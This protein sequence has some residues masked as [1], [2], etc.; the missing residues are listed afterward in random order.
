MRRPWGLWGLA[1]VVVAGL[2]W[3]TWDARG[4]SSAG[5]LWVERAEMQEVIIQRAATGFEVHFIVIKDKWA[6]SDPPGY[7]VD[8]LLVDDIVKALQDLRLGEPFLPTE[9]LEAYGLGLD[10]WRIVVRAGFK[11]V[12]FRLGEGGPTASTYL[13]VEGEDLVFPSGQWLVNRLDRPVEAFVDMRLSH[14]TPDKITFVR[15]Q[16]SVPIPGVTDPERPESELILEIRRQ[17]D[18]EWRDLLTD[19]PLST[20]RVEA[21]LGGILSLEG[22]SLTGSGIIDSA[23]A[24]LTIGVHGEEDPEIKRFVRLGGEWGAWGISSFGFQ[25]GDWEL[26]DLPLLAARLPRLQLVEF[27]PFQDHTIVLPGGQR[28][29]YTR[30]D[31]DP[32]AV[33]LATVLR[34]SWDMVALEPAQ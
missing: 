19:L 21:L 10:S 28:L 3:L 20:R 5:L 1:L 6:L 13:K 12:S 14:T 15:L 29:A 33:I 7:Y 18:G 8:R 26:A 16:T 32:A 11:E 27:D 17:P 24:T 34:T 31:S 30:E 4:N 9:P 23:E 2:G 25:M 22:A